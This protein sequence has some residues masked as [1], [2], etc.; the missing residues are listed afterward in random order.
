MD[1]KDLINILCIHDLE[2]T[3]PIVI[4]TLS[5]KTEDSISLDE[6]PIEVLSPPP[7]E[8]SIIPNLSTLPLLVATSCCDL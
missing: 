2:P 6:E 4:H 5:L 3:Y 8:L 1:L 7:I